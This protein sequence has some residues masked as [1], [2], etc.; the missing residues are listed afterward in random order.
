MQNGKMRSRIRVCHRHGGGVRQSWRAVATGRS[1][2]SRSPFGS[3][4]QIFTKILP[5]WGISHTYVDADK[6][7]DWGET[8]AGK[9]QNGVRG[10]TLQ[11]RA[12]S[13]DLEFIGKFADTNKLIFNVDNCFATP[14]IQNP[15]W[16][17]ARIW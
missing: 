11:S 1:R 3:T 8:S 12:G 13:A 7:Q 17:L 10:I 15:V 6:P 2:W 14:V 9:H 16:I 4:H 5:K